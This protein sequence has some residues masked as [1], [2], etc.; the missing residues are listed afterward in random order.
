M[1]DRIG[2]TAFQSKAALSQFHPRI[3]N[4]LSSFDC[5]DGLLGTL[6]QKHFGNQVAKHNRLDYAYHDWAFE[7][8]NEKRWWSKLDP[9]SESSQLPSISDSCG[10]N[11]SWT[12]GPTLFYACP[13]LGICPALRTHLF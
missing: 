10:P 5:D 6:N 4:L 7:W 8:N 2:K 12:K 13:T 9:E 1:R 11:L 3:S